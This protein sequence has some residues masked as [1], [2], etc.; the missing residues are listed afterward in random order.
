MRLGGWLTF[1]YHLRWSDRVP[2][3]LNGTGPS[4]FNVIHNISLYLYLHAN[5]QYVRD[6]I[7]L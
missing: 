5:I 1:V 4:N 2:E 3:L 6:S 7:P